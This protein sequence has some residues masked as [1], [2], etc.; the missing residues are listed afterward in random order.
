MVVVRLL[1]RRLLH[2]LLLAED[3]DIV[4][5]FCKPCPLPINVLPSGFGMLGHC[6]PPYDDF[7]FLA[8]LLNLL[9]DPGQLFLLYSFVFKVFIFPVFY[10]DLL[11]LGIAL[12]DL[13]R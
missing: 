2:L 4:L 13:Y 11:K 5:K 8:E 3:L 6:L 12:D 7:L 9:L 1:K 10:L